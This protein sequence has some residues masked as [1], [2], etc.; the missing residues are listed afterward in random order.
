MPNEKNRVGGI[1]REK[2]KPYLAR[3]ASSNS[4]KET[5]TSWQPGGFACGCRTLGSVTALSACVTEKA[6]LHVKSHVRAEDHQGDLKHR[7]CEARPHPMQT[8]N[9]KAIA[10]ALIPRQPWPL[11]PTHCT[12]YEILM[13]SWLTA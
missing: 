13:H 10:G 7:K 8:C 11:Q 5:C 6:R 12:E 2:E 3:A 9:R 4:M 1:T